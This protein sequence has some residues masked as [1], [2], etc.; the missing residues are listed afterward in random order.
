M[1]SPPPIEELSTTSYLTSPERKITQVSQLASN[2][3]ELIITLEAMKK[4]LAEKKTANDKN[5]LKH[6]E[7]IK[8]VLKEMARSSGHST[9]QLFNQLP[10]K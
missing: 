4:S 10:Q 1:Y 7:L 9:S 3:Y 8:Q 6:T 2:A 5:A